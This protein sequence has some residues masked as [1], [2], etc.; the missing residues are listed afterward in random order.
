M[1]VI[2]HG[3]RESIATCIN[4]QVESDQSQLLGGQSFLSSDIEARCH[5]SRNRDSNTLGTPI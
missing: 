4:F 5:S 2:Q 1:G 3:R